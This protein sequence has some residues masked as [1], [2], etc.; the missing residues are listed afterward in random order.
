MGFT[1]LVIEYHYL[2]YFR[3]TLQLQLPLN[4][5]FD[6]FQIPSLDPLMSQAL[7][8]LPVN[9]S[10][11]ARTFPFSPT[12]PLVIETEFTLS[13]PHIVHD[14]LPLFKFLVGPP[15]ALRFVGRL[16]KIDENLVRFLMRMNG[17]V[18]AEVGEN[19][20]LGPRRGAGRAWHWQDLGEILRYD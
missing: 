13:S 17:W 2:V 20:G 15:V 16:R 6:F 11:F 5:P 3:P 7:D 18:E 1:N 8:R 14:G 19:G 10:P 12:N 9:P 4:E